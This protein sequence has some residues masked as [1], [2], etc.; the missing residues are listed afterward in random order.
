MPQPSSVEMLGGL[1]VGYGAATVIALALS[2]DLLRGLGSAQPAFGV[3]ALLQRSWTMGIASLASPARRSAERLLILALLG[4]SALAAYAVLAR[5]SQVLE[6]CLQALG[7]GLYPRAL[8]LLADEGGKELAVRSLRLFWIASMAGVMAFTLGAPTLLELIGA[9]AYSGSPYLLPMVAAASCFAALPFS[10]GMS[11]FHAHRIALYAGM[12]MLT[13]FASLALAWTGAWTSQS[14]A[15][16]CAGILA[17]N[18]LLAIAFVQL[19]EK[20]YPV[21]YR[22]GATAI[23]F[24]A[25]ALAGFLPILAGR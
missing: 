18:T 2:L 1:A 6:I 9:K 24:S 22:L 17:G 11:Y 12:L 7:N 10:A 23:A 4:E 3:A 25:L 13:G 21:G 14:L 5:L 20:L 16:W 8:R 19:S 15:G